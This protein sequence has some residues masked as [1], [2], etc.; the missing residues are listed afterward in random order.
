MEDSRMLCTS[1]S[2]SM[3]DFNF[4]NGYYQSFHCQEQSQLPPTSLGNSAKSAS[5]S[6]IGTLQTAVLGFGV[7]INFKS[8]IPVSYSP[9]A[10]L[11]RRVTRFQS[12]T[13]WWFIVL[14]QG[15]EPPA[16]WEEPLQ[17]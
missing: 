9:L 7:C 12:Q 2:V 5:V 14:L 10:L 15:R 1:A 6:D 16:F 4:I 13:F 3:V 17:L 11:N 8:R